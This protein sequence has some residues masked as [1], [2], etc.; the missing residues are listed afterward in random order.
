MIFPPKKRGAPAYQQQNGR[1]DLILMSGCLNNQGDCNKISLLS[2]PTTW[3]L[4]GDFYEK[5]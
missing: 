5:D 3:R 4:N 2:V 1:A